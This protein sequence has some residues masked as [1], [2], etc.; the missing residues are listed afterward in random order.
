MSH[1]DDHQ[2]HHRATM[3]APTWPPATDE[4]LLQL[5]GGNADAVRVVKDLA[6]VSH[7]YDDLIDRDK[8][9]PD[10]HIHALMWKLMVAIPTNPFW[11]ANQQHLL[12]IAIT[13]FLNW[14]A[15]NDMQAGGDVEELRIAHAIRYSLGDVLLMAMTITCGPAHAAANARRARLALQQDTWASYLAEH[16]KEPACP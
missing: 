11:A 7:A 6:F 2:Q 1:L 16:S 3:S 14:R 8:P 5:L 10:E 4:E 13:G 9:V 15:A 12:P